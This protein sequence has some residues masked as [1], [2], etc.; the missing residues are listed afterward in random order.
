MT[1][2]FTST[3]STGAADTHTPRDSTVHVIENSI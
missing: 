1:L 3:T 2:V